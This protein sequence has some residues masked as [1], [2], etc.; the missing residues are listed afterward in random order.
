MIEWRGA[1][2]ALF[3]LLLGTFPRPPLTRIAAGPEKHRQ[4]RGRR[5]EPHRPWMTQGEAFTLV[6]T[7]LSRPARMMGTELNQRTY[8]R[9]QDVMDD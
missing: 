5:R 3:A 4:L 8:R 7:L 9:C 6:F 1:Q 2:Q